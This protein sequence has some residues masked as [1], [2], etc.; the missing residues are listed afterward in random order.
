[1]N[2]SLFD[3]VIECTCLNQDFIEFPNKEKTLIGERG[4][5]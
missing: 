2:K 5:T 1:M 4:V 3:K